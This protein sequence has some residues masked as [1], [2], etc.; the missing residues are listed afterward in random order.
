MLISSIQ[1]LERW[2]LP[3][4]QVFLCAVSVDLATRAPSSLRS[5]RFLTGLQTSSRR[6]WPIVT[7]LSSIDCATIG[8][9]CMLTH[10]CLPWVAFRLQFFTASALTDSVPVLSKRNTRM[11][12][13]KV[14]VRWTQDS[15]LMSSLVRRWLSRC[16]K[17]ETTW[18]S[19][20]RP[21]SAD[22]LSSKATS[23]SNLKPS[24][25]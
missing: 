23:H 18:S 19:P 1:P 9:P 10:K 6:K 11:Q 20:Q 25:E 7:R 24:C 13:H 5:L 8:T 21:K 15:P 17:M 14:S 16:G 3:S 12:T 4:E 2:C 22:W